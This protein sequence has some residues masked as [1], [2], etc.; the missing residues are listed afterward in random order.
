[1]ALM[2]C[3]MKENLNID[4]GQESLSSSSLALTHKEWVCL[5][6]LW[7]NFSVWWIKCHFRFWAKSDL[8]AY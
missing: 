4:T 1:M 5:S 7:V 3:S 8:Y 2:E 6:K